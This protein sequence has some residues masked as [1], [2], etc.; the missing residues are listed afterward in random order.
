MLS[1]LTAFLI[2]CSVA[3]EQKRPFTRYEALLADL[4]KDSMAMM[5]NYWN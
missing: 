1:P 2:H 5:Q 3:P 4:F